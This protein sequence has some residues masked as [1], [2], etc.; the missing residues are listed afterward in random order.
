VNL[1]QKF[2]WPPGSATNSGAIEISLGQHMENIRFEVPL[3][4]LE[5]LAAPK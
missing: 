3:S 1:R 2:Y 5:Q 4:G